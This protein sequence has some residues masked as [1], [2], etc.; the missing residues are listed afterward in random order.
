MELLRKNKTTTKDVSC[1][2]TLESWNTTFLN[3]W[4][5]MPMGRNKIAEGAGVVCPFEINIPEG[6]PFTGIL[7]PGKRV[8]IARLSP[9]TN[10]Y[11]PVSPFF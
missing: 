4:D 7:K 10:F 5:F 8:G 2:L 11:N 1:Q 9:E 3:E 6:S